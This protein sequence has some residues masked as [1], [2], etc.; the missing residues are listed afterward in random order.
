MIETDK[1]NQICFFIKQYKSRLI[2]K[3]NNY[4]YDKLNM[5]F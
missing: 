1:D 4:D 2:N 3:N 5:F